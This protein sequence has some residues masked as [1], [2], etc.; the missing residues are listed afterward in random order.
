MINYNILLIM[1]N[2]VIKKNGSKEPFDA[3]K[4]RKSIIAAAQGT[5]L[6]EERINEVVEQVSKVALELAEGKEE[7]ATSE[8]REKILGE[9]DNVEPSIS[10]GWRKHD[11]EKEKT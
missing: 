1:A 11:Q 7:I 4:I 9:L 5:N 8:L 3:E 2:F 6:S 10:E